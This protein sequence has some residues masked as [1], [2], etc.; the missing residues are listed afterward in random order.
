MGG[1]RDMA[2]AAAVEICLG[3][4]LR[5]SPSF[6]HG[7]LHAIADNPKMDGYSGEQGIDQI[8][9]Q[10]LEATQEQENHGSPR[11]KMNKLQDEFLGKWVISRFFENWVL[12]TIYQT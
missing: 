10:P 4:S 6:G 1:L 2:G 11:I 7:L 5:V 12:S 3:R 8:D 9:P